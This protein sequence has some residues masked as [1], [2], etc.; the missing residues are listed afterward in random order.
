MTRVSDSDQRANSLIAVWTTQDLCGCDGN[1]TR[2]PSVTRVQS[3]LQLLKN[4]PRNQIPSL[5]YAVQ[6]HM[7]KKSEDAATRLR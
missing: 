2:R 3:L 7:N 1:V 4:T 5:Y 6:A